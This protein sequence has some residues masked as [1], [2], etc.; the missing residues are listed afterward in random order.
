MPDIPSDLAVDLFKLP[1][2]EAIAFL[3]EK[4]Y[5]ITWD[6]EEQLKLNAAQVFTVA[7]A[8]K[9][10]ILQDIRSELERS[11]KQGQTFREFKKNLEPRL[12]ALGW[13]GKAK[14]PKTGKII[15]LG[16]PARLKTI[17]RTNIQSSLNAG[18]WNFQQQNKDD[19]PF[20]RYEAVLDASTRPSH[21]QLH[22]IIKHIDDPFWK[23]Y[24]PPNGFGCR[25]RAIAMTRQETIRRGG[26]TRA[27]PKIEPDKGFS[28]NPGIKQWKPK[29][30]KYDN[31]IWKAGQPIVI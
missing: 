22:G 23:K 28:N 25:C 7:K 16:S 12:R 3:E 31:D 27:K 9:M 6:W 14:D 4:D 13:W 11:L 17:Y 8:A 19:R 5:I 30:S 24:Y 29:K 21:A 20:L 1:P 15:Q 10:D 2:A 26:I 18:H